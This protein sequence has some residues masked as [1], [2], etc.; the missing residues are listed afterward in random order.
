MVRTALF[1]GLLVVATW[2]TSYWWTL[3]LV[4]LVCLSSY[5]LYVYCLRLLTV[6][7]PTHANPVRLLLA[8][9]LRLS[10]PGYPLVLCTSKLSPFGLKI[11]FCLKAKR[12]PF[13]FSM[14]ISSIFAFLMVELH[15]FLARHFLIKLENP[16]S[17]L[18]EL[19]LVPF[20]LCPKTG[21][22]W[23]D[24]SYICN[25][26]FA[27]NFLE[28]DTKLNE[29]EDPPELKF[30]VDLIDEFFDEFGLY[31]VHFERW[32]NEGNNVHETPGDFLI[33]KE[34]FSEKHRPN[35]AR[36]VPSF[37][38]DK[39]ARFFDRRQIRR[40]AYL[41]AISDKNVRLPHPELPFPPSTVSHPEFPPTWEFLSK[42]YDEILRCCKEIF[43]KRDCLFGNKYTIAD[44]SVFGIL[45]MNARQDVGTRKKMEKKALNLVLWLDKMD[46]ST[47][48]SQNFGSFHLDSILSDLVPLVSIILRIF[49]PLMK[50]NEISYMKIMSEKNSPKIFNEI[51]FNQKK[52]LFRGKIESNDFVSVTKTFQVETWRKLKEK[53][54]SLN[55]NQQNFLELN[56]TGI[57]AA[58]TEN[59]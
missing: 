27:G 48:I 15:V 21:K 19:P 23:Y 57:S 53:W 47:E 45:N 25:R 24:S 55:E 1:L 13:V 46:K 11:S 4:C 52:S 50:Q 8:K 9:L 28:K 17:N 32:C 35:M 54:N 56:F 10:T 58:F 51:A 31:M 2:F 7:S 12:I 42:S 37:V 6:R 43:S 40:L 49:P 33:K 59:E 39:L 22:I 29:T 3:G 36:I 26:I 18:G 14:E 34:I 16:P 44:A 38:K 20:V 5:H 41:F 30:L